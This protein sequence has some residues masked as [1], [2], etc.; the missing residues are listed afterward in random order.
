MKLK[1]NYLSQVYRANELMDSKENQ[2]L[3]LRD[4][5]EKTNTV[6]NASGV[7]NKNLENKKKQLFVLI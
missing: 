4:I 5:T 7:K 2:I 6:F 1:K 3:Y